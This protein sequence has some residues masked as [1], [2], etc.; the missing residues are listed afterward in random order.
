[1]N[2]GRKNISNLKPMQESSASSC[3]SLESVSEM[4]G[5]VVSEKSLTE[6]LKQ[7]QKYSKIY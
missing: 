2:Q 3:M 6:E 7:K 4:K 5:A 1:M